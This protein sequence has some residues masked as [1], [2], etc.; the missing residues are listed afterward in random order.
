[1]IRDE[2]FRLVEERQSVALF[3]LMDYTFV[4]DM[5]LRLE[6]T[7]R[8]TKHQSDVHLRRLFVSHPSNAAQPVLRLK[9]RLG[10]TPLKWSVAIHQNAV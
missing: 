9:S 5:M 7:S 1:M 2:L 10:S 4:A 3:D 6:A 8:W